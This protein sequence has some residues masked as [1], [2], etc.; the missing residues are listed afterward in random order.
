MSGV[1]CVC[2]TYGR[3]NLLKESIYSFLMQTG[4]YEK[5][6]IIVNDHPKQDIIMDKKYDNIHVFN[7]KRRLRTLGEKRNL[8]C[9]LCKYDNILVWD[10]DDIYLPWRIEETMK[11]L[12]KD[13]FYKCPNAWRMDNGKLNKELGYNLYHSG[14]A[15]TRWLYE[16]TGCYKPINTGEDTEWEYRIQVITDKKE[17]YRPLTTLPKD[18]VYYIYR[19]GHGSY[20]TTW[21]NNLDEIN[22]II[23]E[24]DIIIT[25]H[26]DSD[27][28]KLTRDLL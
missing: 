22:P 28:I 11:K 6:L 8:S 17:E 13:Q 4:N 3:P 7:I 2:L 25:P 20:H 19:W 27:Y 26:W 5:E 9:S 23:V 1:S 21:V 24:G 16:K 10:D 18:R 15:F 14:S 12:E